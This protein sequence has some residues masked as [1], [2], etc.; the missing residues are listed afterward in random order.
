VSSLCDKAPGLNLMADQVRGDVGDR[1]NG[2]Q[3]NFYK[4][5]L[6]LIKNL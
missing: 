4:K 2:S 3:R 1:S 6:K 5:K